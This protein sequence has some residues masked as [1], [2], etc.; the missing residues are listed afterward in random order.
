MKKLLLFTLC[1]F[2]LYFLPAQT[3]QLGV[4]ISKLPT[5]SQISSADMG[6]FYQIGYAQ[7]LYKRVSIETGLT[8]VG[9]NE[10]MQESDCLLGAAYVVLTRKVASLQIPLILTMN[11]LPNKISDRWG[12]ILGFGYCLNQSRYIENVRMWKDNA[13][14]KISYNDRLSLHPRFS[15]AFNRK[16]TSKVWLGL[17]YQT[18]GLTYGIFYPK[19][20]S[21]NAAWQ[22]H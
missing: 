17:Q 21:L 2:T 15:M 12:L 14:Q 5:N 8:F 7:K 10:K 20:L 6:R 18:G 13:L 1:I 11:V 22:L 3:L 19:M 4:G 9:L 16:I